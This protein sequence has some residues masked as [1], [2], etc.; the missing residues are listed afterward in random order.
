MKK[1]GKITVVMYA[2]VIILI[3]IIGTWIAFNLSW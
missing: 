2:I 1:N 3:M